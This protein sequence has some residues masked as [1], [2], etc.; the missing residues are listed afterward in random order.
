[1]LKPNWFLNDPEGLT[2]D[3]LVNEMYSDRQRRAGQLVW[4]GGNRWVYLQARPAGS[5]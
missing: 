5:L 4:S 2:F 3:F 1:M